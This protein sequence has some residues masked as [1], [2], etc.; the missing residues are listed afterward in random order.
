M[1]SLP[2]FPKPY[3]I[4][5]CMG[6]VKLYNNGTVLRCNDT[7]FKASYVED[8]SVQY[9]DYL[10]DP[11]N[12]L[13]LRVYKPIS[14][15][16]NPRFPVIFF[17]HGGGFCVGS[18][19]WSNS[20]N[21]CIR[22]ASTLKVLV[23]SIDYRLAPERRLP[24]AME[25]AFNAVKWLQRKA[26]GLSEEDNEC[27]GDAA[28]FKISEVDFDRVFVV[29]DSSGGNIAH[30][31]AVRVGSDSAGFDPVRVRGYVLLAP[32]FGGVDR[33]KSEEGPSETVLNLDILDMFWRLCLPHGEASRD[34][35]CVNPFG[36]WS[37]SLEPLKLDP[38]L[39]VAGECELLKDRAKDYAKRLKEMGKKI[40]YIEF[41]GEEHGFFT[42]D[43]YSEPANKFV[44]ILKKFI[45][46]NST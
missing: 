42:D 8:G 34:H 15:N 32:F 46:E 23:V 29:G 35:F 14:G 33:T 43:P 30:H 17:I 27:G 40:N 4:E 38:I 39:V 9:K 41:E 37:P 3:V 44:E 28:W 19:S 24:A 1:G 18:F 2:D 16:P 31:L 22:L 7:K 5:D 25:D 21:S 10:Y 26:M 6:A 13:K 20:H 45:Y 36:P 11:K 12:E